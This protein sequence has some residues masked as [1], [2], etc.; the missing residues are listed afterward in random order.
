MF[1]MGH[2]RMDDYTRL[3]LSPECGKD[4]W[5]KILR[6]KIQF[7][8]VTSTFQLSAPPMATPIRLI[9]NDPHSMTLVPIRLAH[10][11]RFNSLRIAA[12]YCSAL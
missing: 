1:W 6:G 3:L 2:D 4:N 11:Y 8:K 12:S 5:G 7:K 9:I 10:G